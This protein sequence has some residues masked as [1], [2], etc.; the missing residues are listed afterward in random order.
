MR[1]S[2]LYFK[3]YLLLGSG[4]IV[5][6]EGF[7]AITGE[8]GAGKSMLLGIINL[9]TGGKVSWES[10][11]SSSRDVEISGVF[12]KDNEELIVK[13]II[14]P[15]KKRSRFLLNDSPVTLKTVVKEIGSFIEIS[16]QH[17]QSS[18]L[19]EETHIDYYDTLADI[20]DERKEY[21]SLYYRYIQ[22]KKRLEN[23]QKILHEIAEKR[24][25]LR[26]KL[27]E[28]QALNTYPGEETELEELIFRLENIESLRQA[29]EDG[30][31]TFYESQES[32]YEKVSLFLRR[33]QEVL[34]KDRE[35]SKVLPLIENILILSEEIFNKLQELA[36]LLE[37]DPEE[38]ENKRKRL[39]H[40]REVMAKYGFSGTSEIL[41]EI[42][43]LRTKISGLSGKENELEELKTELKEQLRILEAK[44]D[45]LSNKRQAVKEDIERKITDELKRLG[46]PRVTFS[47]DIKPARLSEKGK[48]LVEFKISTTGKGLSSLKSVA[49]GG[50]LSRILLAFKAL[51]AQNQPEKLLLF[52]EIDTG[53]GG[54]TARVVGNRLKNLSQYS[55]VIAITHLPQIA[56][57]ADAHFIAERK[58]DGKTTITIR[59][60]SKDERIIEI[61]R[62]LSGDRITESAINHAK[63]LMEGKDNG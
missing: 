62:M 1:L 56:S 28:L 26:F 51:S 60:L 15:S 53:I 54:K 12:I 2:E 23:K 3:N 42:Q 46:F 14:M 41:E 33:Y 8:T 29:F 39:F 58:D 7:N 11:H 22:L 48:D 5:F 9:L 37:I 40:L 19:K 36:D 34:Q 32:V 20:M 45:S 52:D 31:I 18:L 44:A 25:Y 16:S 63:T 35:G 49:S 17:E 27:K 10:F 4:R 59:E 38:L 61:A 50:E 47:I 57:L 6:R 43:N 13:R 30:I 55:Q 24:E 21:E